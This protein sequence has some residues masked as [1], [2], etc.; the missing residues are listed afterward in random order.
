M[1]QSL[2]AL[3]ALNNR[4]PQ[5]YYSTKSTGTKYE[6]LQN[7]HFLCEVIISPEEE[8]RFWKLNYVSVWLKPF[9]WQIVL[10]GMVT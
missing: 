10:Q 8:G 1:C 3:H 2:I 9:V 7:K 6:T 5:R 4:K